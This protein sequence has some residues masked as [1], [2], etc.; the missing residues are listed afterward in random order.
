MAYYSVMDLKD[1]FFG[2]PLLPKSQLIFIFEDH[3]QKSGQ[4]I[5]TVLPQGFRDSSHLFGLALTQDLAEWQ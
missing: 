5:W 3:T 2:I 4:V 1:A